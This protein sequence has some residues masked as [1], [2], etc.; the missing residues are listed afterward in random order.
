MRAM[1]P[2]RTVPAALAVL[3]LAIAGALLISGGSD[4]QPSK[5]QQLFRKTLLDDARTTSAIKKLLRERGGIV[6]PEI[7]FAD[8]TGDGRSDAVVR[9]D[10]GGAAGAVAVYV[11]STDGKAE[12]SPL[13][14]IYR[15]QRLYR[16]KA[17]VVDATLALRVP[18]Y[19]EGDDVC[20]PAKL[21]ERV[22]AWN[23]AA[24]ELRQRSSQ[25]LPGPTGTT[26]TTTT[27]TPAPAR[28]RR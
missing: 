9:V 8:L 20:C 10:S 21:V 11:F 19:I 6:A 17:E 12:D 22:Y 28:T 3:A 18:R 7:E 14:A 13:R 4:A 16:A 26:P 25:E 5:S 15:S 23:D 2:L 1:R 24:K 27:T